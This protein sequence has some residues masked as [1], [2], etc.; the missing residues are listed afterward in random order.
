MQELFNLIQSYLLNLTLISWATGFYWIPNQKTIAYACIFKCFPIKIS[1]LT[2]RS[3]IHFESNFDSNGV[4]CQSFTSGYPIFQFH[5]LRSCFFSNYVLNTF[6][7]KYVY[8]WVSYWIPLVY[9]SV[10]VPVSY[11]FLYYYSEV[12]WSQYC[13]TS[14]IALFAQVFFG[15]SGYFVLP[16]EC[17][18]Q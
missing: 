15:C 9:M 12:V 4:K 6:V 8:S 13:D 16:Y 18:W 2:F 5:L 11:H 7:K 10:F 17:C 14:N 1:S 3:F